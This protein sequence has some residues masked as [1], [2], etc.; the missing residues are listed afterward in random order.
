MGEMSFAPDDQK[1]TTMEVDEDG[2][3]PGD[4]MN[5][6]IPVA[7]VK[8]IVKQ[9]RDIGPTS[10]A[11][12]QALGAAAKLFVAKF[13]ELAEANA[14]TDG[15]VR[16]KYADFAS[17]VANNEELAF[18]SPI[19]PRKVPFAQVKAKRIAAGLEET[20]EPCSPG[21]SEVEQDEPNAQLDEATEDE[22]DTAGQQIDEVQD[23][24]VS[25]PPAQ[26]SPSS[27]SD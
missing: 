22:G 18:L 4:T 8:R 26:I 9:D 5:L 10:A 14:R 12:I 24:S 17:A 15:R 16:L 23:L 6:K 20:G 25:P 2:G 27:D 11:S 13:T 1:D 7:R 19:V 3:D 21:E